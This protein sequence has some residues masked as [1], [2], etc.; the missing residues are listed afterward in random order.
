M[1]FHN[2]FPSVT[3]NYYCKMC[4]SYLNY[5]SLCDNSKRCV[6]WRCWV[7]FDTNDWQRERCFQVRMRN[8]SFLK[9]KSLKQ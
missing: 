5:G 2:Y 9:P 3:M 4:I 1:I 8:M 7:L 6:K